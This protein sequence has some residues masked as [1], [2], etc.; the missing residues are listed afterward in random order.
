MPRVRGVL[1]SAN[2][3]DDIISYDIKS[4]V[5]TLLGISINKVNVMYL[6]E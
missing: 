1:I 6:K 4:A 2:P 3:I 5:S